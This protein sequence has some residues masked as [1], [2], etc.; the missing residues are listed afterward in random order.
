MYGRSVL[1]LRVVDLGAL[2]L[3]GVIDVKRL[4]LGVEIDGRDSRF[5][6]AVAGFLCAAEG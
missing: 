3:V 5:A 6:V 2:E 4:P 1:L